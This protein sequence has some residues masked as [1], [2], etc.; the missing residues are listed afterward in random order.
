MLCLALDVGEGILKY[1][2]EINR[3]ENTIERICKAYGASHVEI[4]AIPSVIIAAVRMKDGEYSSQIRRIH[5][6][7]ND[8]AMVERYNAISY[9][10]CREAPEL[11]EFDKMIHESKTKR[12]MPSWVSLLGAA[13]AA[14][15]FAVF[16]GGSWRDGIVA[17]VIGVVMTLLDKIRVNQVNR[18]AK[19]ALQSFFGGVLAYLSVMLGL[20]DNA[21]M[22]I[23][24]TIM[25]LIPGLYFG[26][27]L[28]DLLCGD[29]LA[30]S[31]K[32]VQALLI[33]LMIAFGYL[34][35]MLV[36]GGAL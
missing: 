9:T 15:S 8:L 16:F 18:F 35:A 3:V 11:D 20:G 29:F 36:T 2:G 17:C 22:I 24:G 7:E 19:T 12:A 31:L 1:G 4:F 13:M 34:L 30:G 23:I 27:A 10:I 14:G 6:V 5:T 32:T 21:G 26:T 33:A 28:R 25:L